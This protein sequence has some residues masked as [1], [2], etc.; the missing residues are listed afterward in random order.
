MMSHRVPPT[1]L[2]TGKPVPLIRLAAPEEAESVA[3]LARE[4]FLHA[5]APTYS[6]EGV[7]TFLEF[8]SGEAMR[9]RMA[10]C[11]TFVA[12][13]N[14]HIVG[15]A[16]LRD[17][18]HLAMLFVARDEQRTGIGRKLLAAVWSKC[19]GDVLTVNSSPNAQEAYARF[20]FKRVAPEQTVK[21][22]RFVA[23][24]M[25]RAR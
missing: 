11:A 1:Q 5:V 14:G 20:G 10:N 21:G 8:A 16:Q 22:I 2:D 19:T 9:E 18:A 24:A 13:R 15:M 4:S 12:C 25:E 6:E 17:G 3:A 23:M 7:L